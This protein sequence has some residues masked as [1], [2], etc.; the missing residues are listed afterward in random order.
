MGLSSRIGLEKGRAM[1]EKT[2]KTES[3]RFHMI[4]CRCK[5]RYGLV[6][7]VLDYEAHKTPAQEE[8]KIWLQERDIDA[9]IIRCPRCGLL[10]LM[11]IFLFD[12]FLQSVMRQE[13]PAAEKQDSCYSQRG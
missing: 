9:L 8:V 7:G 13:S 2:P 1:S 10:H 12:R 5:Y 6:E 11:V 3:D 4:C